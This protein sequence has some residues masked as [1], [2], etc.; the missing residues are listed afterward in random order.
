MADQRPRTE[1]TR[2]MVTDNERR[3]ING[4]GYGIC[5]ESIINNMKIKNKDAN[6]TELQ[7]K[8][9]NIFFFSYET[10]VAARID[11]RYY[12]TSKHH[13]A[14]TTRHVNRFLHGDTVGAVE[15][16]QYFFDEEIE[17]IQFPTRKLYA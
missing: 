1:R 15:K 4:C 10:P 12:K 14:T 5:P 11:S 8:N 16:P 7:F 2:R 9:G 6:A 3:S 13:S 17:R